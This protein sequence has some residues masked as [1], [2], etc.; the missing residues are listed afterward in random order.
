MYETRIEKSSNAPY[1]IAY[2]LDIAETR[3]AEQI[4]VNP[5]VQVAVRK[6]AVGFSVELLP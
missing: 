2:E 5:N 1:L 6:N 3:L 4:R